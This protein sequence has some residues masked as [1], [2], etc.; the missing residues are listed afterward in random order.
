MQI[1]LLETLFLICHSKNAGDVSKK[2]KELQDL[3]AKK[4]NFLTATT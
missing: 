4:R 2:P 1:E 3:V